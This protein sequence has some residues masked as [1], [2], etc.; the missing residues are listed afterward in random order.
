MNFCRS[1]SASFRELLAKFVEGLITPAF[2]E[3]KPIFEANKKVSFAELGAISLPYQKMGAIDSIDLFGLDELLIFAFYYRNRGRYS[4]AA[5]IGANIGLHS[6]VLSMC[7]CEVEAY[8]PDP[9]HCEKLLRNLNP[10]IL[11]IAKRI[12]LRS[13]KRMVQCNLCVCSVTQRVVI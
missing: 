10:T 5:D 13:L 11:P 8:E 4:R 9:A 1:S 2:H 7:G 12:R 3:A 6:I